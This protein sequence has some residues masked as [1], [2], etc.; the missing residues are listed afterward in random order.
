MQQHH[1]KQLA[2]IWLRPEWMQDCYDY[3][4]QT[5]EGV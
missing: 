3:Q 4:T 1:S 2:N 5:T